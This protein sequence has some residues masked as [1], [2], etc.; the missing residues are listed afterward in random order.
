MFLKCRGALLSLCTFSILA[1]SLPLFAQSDQS[2][3]QNSTQNPF[4]QLHFRPLG[5]IGNRAASIVGEPGN[6]LVIYVGAAAGGI[7]KTEDGGVTWHPVFDDQDVAAVGA[8][9][10]FAVAAQRRLGGHG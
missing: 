1:L 9:A 8:L 7:F 10:D 6:P 2:Q 3:S 5:P 4:R